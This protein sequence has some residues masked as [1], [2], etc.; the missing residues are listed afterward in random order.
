MSQSIRA[1]VAYFGVVFALA[2]ALGVLRVL[3]IAPKFGPVIAVGLEIPVILIASAVACRWAIRRF[4]VEALW[5]QRAAMG[6]LAFVLLMMAEFGL[7]Y[8]F[9]GRAPIEYL[10]TFR[11]LH[12]F[13]GLTAQILFGLM[14][15]MRPWPVARQH[16]R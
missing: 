4:S 16:V 10:E 15:V 12:G 5:P 13:M 8:L 9:S 2:F 6:G 11:T 14:P 1:G 3:V 7:S